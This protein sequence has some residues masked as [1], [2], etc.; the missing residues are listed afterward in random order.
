MLHQKK[1]N[2]LWMEIP[3]V[4]G[5]VVHCSNFNCR[6]GTSVEN[7]S[8]GDAGPLFTPDLPTKNLQTIISGSHIFPE[9][10]FGHENS[11]P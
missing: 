7:A 9:N 8:M 6:R 3:W 2:E 1:K 5:A 4:T 10:S 11:I